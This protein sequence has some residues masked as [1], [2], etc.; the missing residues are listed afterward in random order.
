[1]FYFTEH[2]IMFI[3]KNV[4]E[5]FNSLNFRLNYIE[6]KVKSYK[7]LDNKILN[8]AD[9]ESKKLQAKEMIKCKYY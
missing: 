2:G 7:V 9:L 3:Q 8:I 5:T 6:N 4:G 1:M